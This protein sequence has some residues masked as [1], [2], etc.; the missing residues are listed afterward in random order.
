MTLIELLV[1]LA[2]ASVVFLA[3]GTVFFRGLDFS[4]YF[5]RSAA[6]MEQLADSINQLSAIMPQ[7]VRVRSCRC[8]GSAGDEASCTWDSS[9]E[10]KDPVFDYGVVGH[11][12]PVVLFDA[13]YEWGF[14][15]TS[16]F[17]GGAEQYLN[18]D[19]TLTS[20]YTGAPLSLPANT[21]NTTLPPGLT[22]RGCRQRLQLIYTSASELVSPHAPGVLTIRLLDGSGAVKHDLN[23]G[24]LSGVRSRQMGL[25]RMSCGFAAPEAGRLGTDFVINL[26]TKVKNSS[27]E[28]V[29]SSNY[30]SWV[31]GEQNYGRGYFREAKLRF[32]FLNLAQ[33]GAY[34]WRM[35]ANKSCSSSLAAGPITSREQCCSFALDTATQKC[36][37]ECVPAG[38]AATNAQACCSEKWNGGNCL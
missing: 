38:D 19:E 31:V 29:G 9:N 3:A 21:C 26:R 23:I 30:E 14:G 1:G 12:V 22:S 36:L 15:G 11:G 35:L 32:S 7:V 10:F 17:I 4:N 20:S 13:D 6:V 28:D 24:T 27:T 25:V 16:S 8:S 34:Q 2:A 5:T 33:R 18:V 37:S